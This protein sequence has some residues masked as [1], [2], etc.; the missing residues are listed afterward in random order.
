MAG[1]AAHYLTVVSSG[2][3]FGSQVH[4]VSYLKPRLGLHIGVK[5]SF[6]LNLREV[7]GVIFC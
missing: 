6:V 5:L 3:P 2:W 1:T 4:H 7:Y